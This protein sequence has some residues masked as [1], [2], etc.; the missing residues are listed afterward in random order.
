MLV[1]SAAFTHKPRR[2]RTGRRAWLARSG[3]D[4]AGAAERLPAPARRRARC[5]RCHHESVAAQDLPQNAEERPV[6]LRRG[7]GLFHGSNR[8]RDIHYFR[9]NPTLAKPPRGTHRTRSRRHSSCGTAISLAWHAGAANAKPA[10][11]TVGRCHLEQ[12][13]PA[14][15]ATPGST[16]CPAR[17]RR[18]RPP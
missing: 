6:C 3:G 2:D 7:D 8:C 14:P 18:D 13:T 16:E 11:K 17:G 12:D 5:A 10:A 15:T 9:P 4:P 1:S